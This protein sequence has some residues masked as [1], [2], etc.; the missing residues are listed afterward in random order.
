MSSQFRVQVKPCSASRIHKPS[1]RKPSFFPLPS[2]S[3]SPFST[4][5][6]RSGISKPNL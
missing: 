3:S 4:V 5:A 1:V 6:I 2:I